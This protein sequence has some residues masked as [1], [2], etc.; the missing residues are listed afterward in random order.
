M[1]RYD[2][3]CAKIHPLNSS[4]PTIPEPHGA[5]APRL[6]ATSSPSADELPEESSPQTSEAPSEEGLPSFVDQRPQSRQALPPSPSAPLHDGISFP[7]QEGIDQI[8]TVQDVQGIHTDQISTA[9][10]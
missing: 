8:V 7:S 6:P 4:P 9:E 3:L 1:L 10:S 2:L 5:S